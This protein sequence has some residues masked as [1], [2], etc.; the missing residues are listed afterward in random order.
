[1]VVVG[2]CGR[3]WGEMGKGVMGCSV[4]GGSAVGEDR[5]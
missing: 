3:V 4:S 2:V 5:C 1:M